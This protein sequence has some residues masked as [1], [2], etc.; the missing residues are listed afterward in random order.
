MFVFS[1][2]TDGGESKLES[3]AL[4]KFFQARAMLVSE[5]GAS[6]TLTSEKKLK[7]TNTIAYFLPYNEESMYNFEPCVQ[8]YKNLYR[9]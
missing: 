5:A 6:L 8:C 7:R 9:F 4:G 2:F 3:F 1:F